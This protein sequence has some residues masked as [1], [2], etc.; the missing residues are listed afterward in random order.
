MSPI[1]IVG[2]GFAALNAVRV[3][4]R[5]GHT[6]P[7][8]LI[9]PNRHLFY[10]PSLI[11]VPAGLRTEAELTI[12]LDRFI[13]R[14]QIDHL[15]A[16][17][18]GLL[19]HESKVITDQGEVCY[20]HLLIASGGRLIRKLPG[21]ENVAIPCQ[22]YAEVARVRDRL[23]DMDGG[24]IAFGFASNPKE[25]SAMRGGPIFEFLF[26]IDSLLRR[27]GRRDRFRLVFFSPAARPGQRLGA[28]AVDRLLDEMV[29]RD[30][31]THLGHK[32]TRF[33]EGEVVTEGGS[34][35]ADL[36]LFMPGMTGPDWAAESGLPLSPGGFFQSDEHCRIEGFDN[37][38]VAGDSGS[39][40]GPD[41]MPKQAHMADLQAE[42]A[43]QN[44]LAVM[45]GEEAIHTFRVELLCIIDTLD[46]GILVLRT[47][48]RNIIFR[49]K[50]FHPLKNLYEWWFLRRFL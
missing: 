29:K 9:S 2:S 34:F 26:G 42:V 4:R 50:L 24:T 23:A 38:F 15:Q 49:M 37:I 12:P 36:V 39:F 10:Y 43:C 46:D 28:A 7:V 44:L 19:P 3:L 11:W 35:A 14:Y 13:S 22:N 8:T 17:V 45:H 47:F 41:W 32:M 33:D 20:S 18:T 48:K 5:E 25:P 31:A 6:G 30:I 40:P 1:V 16:R 21:I 27:Q